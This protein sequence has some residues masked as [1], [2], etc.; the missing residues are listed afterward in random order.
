MSYH[1]VSVRDRPGGT[2]FSR[3]Q[4]LARHARN[5]ARGKY[6]IVQEN[7]LFVASARYKVV[8]QVRERNVEKTW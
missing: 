3:L 2:G 6:K 1:M 5:S 7:S 8:V 4:R